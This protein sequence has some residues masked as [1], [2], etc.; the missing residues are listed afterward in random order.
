M[1]LR[2]F[3]GLG[4]LLTLTF[5]LID[6]FRFSTVSL[7]FAEKMKKKLKILPHAPSNVALLSSSFSVYENDDNI[8]NYLRQTPTCK[9]KYDIDGLPPSTLLQYC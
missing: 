2:R 3:N 4:C 1:T 5:L 7:R 6:H 9:K 8:W